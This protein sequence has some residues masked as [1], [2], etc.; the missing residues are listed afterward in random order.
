MWGGASLQVGRTWDL[1]H[2]RH[3]R[4]KNP[5]LRNG[6]WEIDSDKIQIQYFT[7]SLKSRKMVRR[8]PNRFN[9]PTPF[10]SPLHQP[11]QSIESQPDSSG[12][13]SIA[14]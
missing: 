8:R 11:N 9:I 6:I 10:N 2:A 1:V 4:D 14:S 3:R 5:S 12:S 7:K 13:V